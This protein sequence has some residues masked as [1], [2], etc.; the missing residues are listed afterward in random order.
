LTVSGHTGAAHAT[1]RVRLTPRGGAD[2]VEGWAMG[3][4]GTSH[5]KM[6]VRAVA[7]GGKANMAAIALLADALAVPKSAI[8]IAA[9]HTARL[10]SIEIAGDPRVLEV[11]LAALGEGS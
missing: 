1:I 9:G 10:K 2:R 11:R 4:D 5:L 6:R 8:R 7:E 3:A